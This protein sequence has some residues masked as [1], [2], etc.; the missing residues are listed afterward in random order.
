M[1]AVRKPEALS[2]VPRH[3]VMYRHGVV[4]RV[5]HWINA[6]II[7]LLFASGLLEAKEA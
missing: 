5:T 3:E 4:V 7:I 6:I 1:T 2:A